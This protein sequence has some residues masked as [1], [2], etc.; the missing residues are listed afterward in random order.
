M[1]ILVLTPLFLIMFMLIL[2]V[3]IMLTLPLTI[4]LIND[5][6]AEGMDMLI[7]TK[8]RSEWHEC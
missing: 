7:I 1:I 3:T 5:L 4:I 6:F 8:K 2:I